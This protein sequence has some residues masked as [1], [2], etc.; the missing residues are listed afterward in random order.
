MAG[1]RDK[2]PAR[3]AETAPSADVQA[4]LRKVAATPSPGAGASRGRLMFALDATASRQPTWDRACRIQAE[5]FHATAAIGGLD[6]QLVF[7]RG[8]GECKAS[9]WVSD[10]AALARK[11]TAV[12][13]LGGQTQI[14]TDERRVG[15]G[16][17]ST[18]RY[19]WSPE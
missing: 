4:F 5:M 9:P 17:V 13:C 12:G 3:P 16:G 10:A 8:F 7:Y 14:R 11:M 6:V 2:T 18:C 1:E 15:R 19:G